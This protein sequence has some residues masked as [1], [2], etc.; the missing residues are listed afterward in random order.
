MEVISNLLLHWNIIFEGF[1]I[2]IL[3]IASKCLTRTSDMI[4]L[5]VADPIWIHKDEDPTPLL[6]PNRKRKRD[7][8]EEREN[9]TAGVRDNSRAG[10]IEV[11]D[12]VS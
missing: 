3:R 11:T 6:A 12:S 5:E 9:R 10:V 2:K 4:V 8:R 7:R 1:R